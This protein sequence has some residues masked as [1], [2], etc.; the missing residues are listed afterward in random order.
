MPKIGVGI[1]ILNFILKHPHF[2][3]ELLPGDYM[4]GFSKNEIK[5]DV[6]IY[7]LLGNNTEWE[8]LQIFLNKDD[9]IEELKKYK[10]SRIEIF[11]KNNDKYISTYN[12][13]KL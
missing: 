10:H 4:N 2:R 5:N 8:D 9:A 13:I 6:F 1:N 3:T 12:Y 11:K 7:I